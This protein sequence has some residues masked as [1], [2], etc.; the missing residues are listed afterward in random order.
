MLFKIKNIAPRVLEHVNMDIDAATCIGLSGP[1]GAGKTLLLRQLADMDP[2]AGD[3]LLDGA[4]ID[5]I[6]AHLWRAR[7]ALLPAESQ[8]WFDSVGE[9]FSEIDESVLQKLGFEKA[10]LAWHVSRLSSGEKQR[11][12]LLRMLALHPR[13]LLLDEPTANL[14]AKFVERVEEI[15]KEYKLSQR[16]A[17][18]WVSHDRKHL[19]RVADRLLEIRDKKL[20]EVE[21]E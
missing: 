21:H 2:R 7:V 15:L 17:L 14:D 1:S 9:H 8:W 13:V 4:S 11:L 16:A 18:L 12:A 19:R 10:V 6:P 3:V 20:Y 5:S